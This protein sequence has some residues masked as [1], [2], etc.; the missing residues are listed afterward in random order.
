MTRRSRAA[1]STTRQSA[2]LV[3]STAPHKSC[4]LVSLKTPQNIDFIPVSFI[5]FGLCVQVFDGVDDCLQGRLYEALRRVA[6]MEATTGVAGL[7]DVRRVVLGEATTVVAAAMTVRKAVLLEATTV[8]AVAMVVRRVA[9]MEATA[10]VAASAVL[11]TSHCSRVQ[12]GLV[13]RIGSNLPTNV[14]LSSGN[15]G[16][17]PSP[18]APCHFVFDT[19]VFVGG[20]AAAVAAVR[21]DDDVAI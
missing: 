11:E 1:V 9:M 7:L 15:H 18:L 3:E 21:S 6:M 13:F 17:F 10:V 5:L 2:L 19:R 20:V 16:Y 12:C 8:V 4:P 14:A